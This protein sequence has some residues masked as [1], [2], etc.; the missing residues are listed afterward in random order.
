LIVLVFQHVFSDLHTLLVAG[1]IFGCIVSLYS[2]LNH[3]RR[4]DF[5]QGTISAGYV[6]VNRF[7]KMI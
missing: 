3:G 7:V 5:F 2:D 1:L 6:R 4:M